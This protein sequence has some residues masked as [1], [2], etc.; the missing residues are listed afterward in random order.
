MKKTWNILLSLSALLISLPLSATAV[1]QS[2]QVSEQVSQTAPNTT[3]KKITYSGSDS[4]AVGDPLGN[5][6]VTAKHDAGPPLTQHLSYDENC[7][8][9]ACVRARKR[10]NFPTSWQQD[11]RLGLSVGWGESK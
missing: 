5:S 11:R 4:P 3:L 8:D 1:S 10:W 2:S 6:P 7:Q 9:E